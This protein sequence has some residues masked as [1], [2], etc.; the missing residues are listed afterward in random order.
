MTDEKELSSYKQSQKRIHDSYDLEIEV[1]KEINQ[2]L[3]K[4]D[5][6]FDKERILEY[7]FSLHTENYKWSRESLLAKIDWLV[8]KKMDVGVEERL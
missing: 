2:S 1:I 8:S 7:L 6:Q 3:K 4:I 5:C